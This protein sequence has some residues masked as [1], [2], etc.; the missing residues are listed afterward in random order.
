MIDGYSLAMWIV[1]RIARLVLMVAAVAVLFGFAVGW[2]V[3]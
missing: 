2:W 3:A 1:G